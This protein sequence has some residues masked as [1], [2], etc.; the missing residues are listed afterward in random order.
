MKKLALFLFCFFLSLTAQAKE[1][2]VS[3]FFSEDEALA[4]EASLATKPKTFFS[5]NRNRLS[6]DSLIYFGEGRWTFWL[7]GEK[8]TPEILQKQAVTV[9]D[10]APDAVRLRVDP[11]RAQTSMEITLHPHQSFDLATGK[12]VEG[13]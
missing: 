12:I 13:P 7:Q 8:W 4:I 2:G 10:V 11:P 1:R 3:L 5:R 6:L 9:L